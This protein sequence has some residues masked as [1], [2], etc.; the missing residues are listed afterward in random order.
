MEIKRAALEKTENEPH[1]QNYMAIPM[2]LWSK[3]LLGVK[4]G[5]VGDSQ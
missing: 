5:A 4:A 2:C 3:S 1:L